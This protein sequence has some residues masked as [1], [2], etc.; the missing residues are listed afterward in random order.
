MRTYEDYVTTTQLGFKLF[1]WYLSSRKGTLTNGTCILPPT[2]QYKK[3]MLTLHLFTMGNMINFPVILWIFY[4]NTEP[5]SI[6]IS[7]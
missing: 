2:L 7:Q 4:C 3:R 6:V 5:K 1:Y